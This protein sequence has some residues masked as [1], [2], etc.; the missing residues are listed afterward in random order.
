MSAADHAT[1]DDLLDALT[2]SAREQGVDRGWSYLLSSEQYEAF[3]LRGEAAGF[4]LGLLVRGAAPARRLFVSQVFPSSAAAGAGFQRGDEITAAGPLPG[5]LTPVAAAANDG[6]LGALVAGTVGTP[7]SF[8]VLPAGGGPEVVRTMTPTAA[9]DLDPVPAVRVLEDGT[10]YVALRTF[11]APAEPLLRQAFQRLRDAGVRRVVVDLRYNGGGYVST[12]QVLA[13]L[14]GRELPGR[15][16]FEQRFNARHATSGSTARFG[17]EAAAGAFERVAFV[18]TGASASA[19]ELVPNVLDPYLPVAFAGSATYGK[20]VG[21]MIF[22][23]CASK[24]FLVAFELANAEGDAGYY[25]GLPDATTRGPLCAAEDDLS[26]AQDSEDEASTRAALHFVR[27]G[28]CPASPAASA[29]LRAQAAATGATEPV[30]G[31]GPHPAPAQPARS[32]LAGIRHPA[33][34]TNREA[35]RARPVPAGHSV[36]GPGHS[37]P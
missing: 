10:G 32:V 30:R 11:I 23:A 9:Y 1:A 33:P 27:T 3:F 18:T 7:R 13:N 28:S 12:A 37:A 34:G 14:L 35:I 19:S 31:A 2:A 25:S 22:D 16:M 24:L 5:S 21:Q 29:L 6:T 8:A 4:G 20:P 17:A 15:T 36:G 26:H